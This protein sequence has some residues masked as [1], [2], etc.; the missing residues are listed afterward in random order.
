MNLF[1]KALLKQL[2]ENNFK[3]VQ[4]VKIGIAGAGGLGSNCAFNLTRC[5]FKNFIIAD[6]DKIEYSN[7][8]RQFFFYNQV[9]MPK[10]EALKENL[11]L[12]NPD[13]NI[14]ALNI[15]LNYDNLE[16]IFNDCDI[17]VEAFDKSSCKKM[18]VE[19]FLGSNKLLV[20]ASGLAGWDDSNLITT[21]KIKS[22]F[23]LI[24]DLVSEVSENCPPI[25]PRVNTAAAKQANVILNYV[26]NNFR[27]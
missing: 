5:G 26:I 15:F 11:I 2:G 19:K 9:G 17:I 22:N 23:Y 27:R 3:T 12:I 25:S 10:V 7:L 13:I 24:G 21:R 14:D 18:I 8:N 20:S 1:E 4:S 16:D 6:F